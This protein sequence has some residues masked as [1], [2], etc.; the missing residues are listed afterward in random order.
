MSNCIQFD[1][2]LVLFRNSE[3]D[4]AKFV[5]FMSQPEVTQRYETKYGSPPSYGDPGYNADV[6]IAW[7]FVHGAWRMDEGGKGVWISFGNGRSSHTNR[8]FKTLVIWLRQFML[9][10]KQKVFAI[11]DE[12]DGFRKRYRMEVNFWTP[13]VEGK[14]LPTKLGV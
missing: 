7:W 2:P 11:R 12:F 10:P 4:V 14:A 1:A 13:S 9:M 8:D 5:N 6:N 3:F